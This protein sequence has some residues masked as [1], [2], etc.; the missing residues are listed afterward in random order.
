MKKSLKE[1]RLAVLKDVLESLRLEKYQAIRG[2]YISSTYRLKESDLQKDLKDILPNIEK[3]TCQVCALGS[4]FLS[5]VRKFD[6]YPTYKASDLNGKYIC[7]TQDDMHRHLV[8]EKLWTKRQ[9]E[10]IESAFE[11]YSCGGFNLSAVQF[12]RRHGDYSTKRLKAIVRNMIENG[13]VFC[14]SKAL[15]KIST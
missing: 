6:N 4:I 2:T 14:P 13:G 15:R 8:N 7:M 10:C 12:G 1:R 11:G 5:A 3:K 9:L